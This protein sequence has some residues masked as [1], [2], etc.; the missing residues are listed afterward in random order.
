M[1][2]SVSESPNQEKRQKI[3]SYVMLYHMIPNLVTLLVRATNRYIVV[4][5]LTIIWIGILCKNHMKTTKSQ[6][7]SILIHIIFT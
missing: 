4:Q 5:S 2:S 6:P 7:L 1:I 3:L